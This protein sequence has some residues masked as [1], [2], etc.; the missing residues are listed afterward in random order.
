MEKVGESPIND[1]TRKELLIQ[2]CPDSLQDHIRDL[3]MMNKKATWQHV[4]ELTM[5]KIQLH[6]GIKAAAKGDQMDVDGFSS[7][8]SDDGKLVEGDGGGE[9]GEWEWDGLYGYY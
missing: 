3:T 9:P 6:L 4:R 8:E 2:I 7:D 5:A 1:R